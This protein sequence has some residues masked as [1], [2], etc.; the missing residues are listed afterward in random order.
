MRFVRKVIRWCWFTASEEE[1]SIE[2]RLHG[3]PERMRK[4]EHE[5]REDAE[6]KRRFLKRGK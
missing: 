2:D 5:G 1:Q 3:H 4:V 6:T